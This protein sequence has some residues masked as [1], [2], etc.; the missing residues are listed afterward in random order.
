[1]IR[2]IVRL[3]ALPS[4]WRERDKLDASM[5]MYVVVEIKKT[6][7]RHRE[8]VSCEGRVRDSYDS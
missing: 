8:A 7:L 3:C 2:Y 4:M 1:M 6:Y 5:R